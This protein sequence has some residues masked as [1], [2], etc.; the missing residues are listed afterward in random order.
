LGAGVRH[1]GRA[2]LDEAIVWKVAHEAFHGLRRT[3]QIAGRNIEAGRCV[4]RPEAGSVSPYAVTELLRPS[5]GHYSLAR[6]AGRA[7]HSHTLKL[8]RNRNV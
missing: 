6:T 4:C 3:R 7:G 8:K 1:N 5:G 2:K